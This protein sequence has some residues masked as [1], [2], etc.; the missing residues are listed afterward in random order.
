MIL[1][2][3]MIL[4]TGQADSKKAIGQAS[5]YCAPHIDGT[6]K[7]EGA[8]ASTSGGQQ[9]HRQHAEA[10]DT[11]APDHSRLTSAPSYRQ[12]SAD[13]SPLEQRTVPAS[14][15]SPSNSER[16]QSDMQQQVG[17]DASSAPQQSCDS[18]EPADRAG[19]DAQG[20]D[21]SVN[22]QPPMQQQLE[23]QLSMLTDR[24]HAAEQ[25]AGNHDELQ[26][27][28]QQLK[29]DKAALQADVKQ[30]T[31][32]ISSM[33]T[34]LQSQVSKLLLTGPIHPRPAKQDAFQSPAEKHSSSQGSIRSALPQWNVES[35]GT[36]PSPLARHQIF[37]SDV[38]QMPLSAS[39]APDALLTDAASRSPSASHPPTQPSAASA[40][41]MWTNTD[42]CIFDDEVGLP[43]FVQMT[44]APSA[45]PQQN[46]NFL[47]PQSHALQPRPP[48]SPDQPAQSW[49]EQVEL[50]LPR[51]AQLQP[52]QAD[53]S[54]VSHLQPLL[55]SSLQSI[56][57]DPRVPHGGMCGVTTV[58]QQS[59]LRQVPLQTTSPSQGLQH[60]ESFWH[61][62]MHQQSGQ[63]H[64][65]LQSLSLQSQRLGLGQPAH[66]PLHRGIPKQ[67]ISRS[68]AVA[69]PV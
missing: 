36:A 46:P 39:A 50:P 49:L 48:Q 58:H 41:T 14:T 23:A 15:S 43:S 10:S 28:L 16:H 59:G 7:S 30:F 37:E 63:E 68:A 24:L 26:Q 11:L 3:L 6:P 32:H 12:A 61:T 52:S 55:S 20:G 21:H 29:Q 64:L 56:T 1:T 54:G 19:Q 31:E 45:N 51:P 25:A 35:H 8:L 18:S 62:A 2:L 40:N 38:L 34:T 33:L 65:P 69:L 67:H 9:S 13:L 22:A 17:A 57:A 47:P 27:Q 4:I 5:E 66:Q 53:S 42:D 60:R 44:T